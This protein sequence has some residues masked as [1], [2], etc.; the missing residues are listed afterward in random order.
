MKAVRAFVVAL[1]ALAVGFACDRSPTGLP[2]PLAPNLP[3]ARRSST[4]QQVGLVPC[5]DLPYDSVTRVIG[6]S[7]GRISIGP[8]KLRI[9]RGALDQS[10][11]IT[12]VLP[13]GTGTNV[14]R[15]EPEGLSF[16]TSVY[17]R[18]SYANCERSQRSKQVAYIDGGRIVERLPS[19]D[20]LP[21]QMVTG[22]LSHFSNYAV[23]W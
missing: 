11:S 22:Q 13:T 19:A 10:T 9:P 8:H 3:L 16:S 4:V 23:A 5:S 1:A 6:P 15:F 14:V 21:P 7:G 18:M 2:Q 12:A 20:D 17:L